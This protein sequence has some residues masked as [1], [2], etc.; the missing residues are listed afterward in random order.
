[1]SLAAKTVDDSRIR[2]RSI[3]AVAFRVLHP[4][5]PPI[6]LDE[7]EKALRQSLVDMEPVVLRFLGFDLTVPL[8]HNHAYLLAA[9]L[10][11]FYRSQLRDRPLETALGTLLQ[12]AAVEPGLLLAHSPLTVALVLLALALQLSG[13]ELPE[14]RW[15]PLFSDGLSL[16]RLQRLKRRF[17]R[18]VYQEE[19]A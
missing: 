19:D 10:R 15:L 4:D 11:D 14:R 1:M 8:P 3:V 17:L 9:A 5:K 16:S 2:L 13:V 7:L 6:G 18:S 12:D